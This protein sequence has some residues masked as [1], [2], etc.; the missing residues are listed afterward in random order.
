[1]NRVLEVAAD[2]FLAVVQPA[3]TYPQ[4]NRSLRAS[5]LFFPVDPGAEA[6]LGGMA[7]T[8]A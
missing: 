2:D 3:V 4:L 1:M 6:S 7:S 5:G 8:N